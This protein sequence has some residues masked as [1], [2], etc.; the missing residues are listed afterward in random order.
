MFFDFKAGA[1]WNITDNLSF[2]LYGA[3][4]ESNI[5]QRRHNYVAKSR[6]QQ[7]LNADNPDTCT[8]TSSGCVPLNLFGP[9][10]S[11]TPA[12]AG[13]I[14]GIASTIDRG[15]TLAQVHGVLSGDFGVTM[16]WASD[17]IA[18][19]VGGE[20]RDYTGYTRP[21][22][23]AQV[24]GELGGAGGAI[25]PTR[26]RL[27]GRRRVC[28]VDRPGR[29]GS[30]VLAGTVAPRPAIAVRT[31]RS[32]S[33]DNPKFSA[34]SYKIGGTWQPVEAIKFRGNWQ[35]AVRAP[36]ISELFTPVATGLTALTT[37][38]C[39]GA[40]PVTNR[41]PAAVCI[42][43]GAP[44]GSIGSIPNPTAGQANQTSGGNPF[45]GPETSRSW[46]A[47]IVLTPRSLIPGFNATLDYYKIK[48]EDAITAPTSGDVI[49]LCFANITAASATDPNCTGIRRNQASGGLSGS[50]SSVPGLPRA[51]VQPGPA[52]DRWLRSHGKLSA[53]HRLLGPDPELQRQLHPP[54]VVPGD[55]GFGGTAELPGPVQRQ[56]RY[57]AWA[58]PAEVQLQPADHAR[59]Q[60]RRCLAALALHR[61]E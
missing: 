32:T 54:R 4:G 29:L 28:R 9:P 34:N 13:F 46:T 15:A 10:G 36:N 14:G 52:Q 35:Q 49:N 47:G 39:A 17:P 11:I 42:A 30:A 27:Y 61:E 31:M 19:A 25:N 22:S 18:F 60:A 23:L 26:G 57:F 8:N 59:I 24:P 12:M 6:L 45:L 16:P 50:V 48:V 37:D 43:Q 44:P 21:D 58:D 38:P 2:D 5:Q 1:T 53:E 51:A 40:A 41:E 3:Y 20:H 33:P 7:A 55:A 56:L